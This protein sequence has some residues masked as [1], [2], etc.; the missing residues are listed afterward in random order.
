MHWRGTLGLVLFLACSAV[1]VT[2]AAVRRREGGSPL[3][4]AGADG[5]V[6]IAAALVLLVLGLVTA[7]VA[8]VYG[9]GVGAIPSISVAGVGGAWLVAIFRSRRKAQGRRG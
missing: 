6:G 7:P 9:L 5:P 1:L 2:G 8:A 4:E 3:R